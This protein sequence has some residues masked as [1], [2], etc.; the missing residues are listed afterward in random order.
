MSVLINPALQWQNKLRYTR[1]ANFIG[2][3]SRVEELKML[4]KEYLINDRTLM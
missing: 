4:L 1:N 3:H 2:F